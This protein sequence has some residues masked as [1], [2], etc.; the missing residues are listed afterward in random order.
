MAFGTNHIYQK[1]SDGTGLLSAA[2]R[3]RSNSAFIP[4]LW[5][6]EIVAAYKSNLVMAPLV[7]NM[8]H[9]GKKGDTIHVPRPVRGSASVKTEQTIVTF[10]AGQATQSNFLID[11][12]WEYSRLLEDIAMIQADDSIRPFYTD[13]AGYALAT[14]I[15]TDLHAEGAKFAGAHASPTV[16]GSNYSKAVIGS[17]GSTAWNPAAASNAGNAAALADAGIREIIRQLDDNDVPSMGRVL[18]IPPVERKTLMGLARF[19]E[20]AYVGEV[21]SSNTI[22]NG[23][24]GNLYGVE[25]YVS[26]NCP[27]VAD[28]ASAVDQRAALLFQKEGLLLIEQMAPRVQTQY[29]QEYLG[30]LFTADI[31]Y[32]TGILRPEAGV[33]I[34][35]PA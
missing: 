29:K 2:T 15:D 35:V 5:S 7:V 27:T 19:T 22:R 13:D 34:V 23:L 24:I 21:G 18:V 10:I 14:K 25:V 30:D 31:L 32:G 20:Q 6:D 1:L 9:K 4:E 33:A 16:A 8:N 3:T 17:D 12:H 26:S 11:Q 28:G